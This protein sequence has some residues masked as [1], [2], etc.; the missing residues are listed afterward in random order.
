MTGVAWYDVRGKK[1][2]RDI[3]ILL[4]PPY[5]IWHLSYVVLGA[6][7]APALDWEPLIWTLL[8]FFL[9]MGIGAHCLDE[10]KGRPLKTR[11]SDLALWIT[12]GVSIAGAIAIGAVVGVKETWTVIPCMV[13]GGFIVFAYTLEWGPKG[14]FHRDEWFGAAWGAFPVVTAYVA[15]THSVSW[16][17]ALVAAACL[18]YSLAQ[19]VLSR[20][21]RFWRRKIGEVDGHYFISD[22]YRRQKHNLTKEDIYAPADLAL[23]YMTW[24]VVAAAVGMLVA[25]I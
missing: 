11:F 20:Q 1:W 3:L 4:H 23:K 9:A 12:A 10:L 19:R 6:A 5:T 8:A 25:K 21:S 24:T 14:F 15:Q 2:V 22:D 13:F 17:I 16:E 7:L 18:L